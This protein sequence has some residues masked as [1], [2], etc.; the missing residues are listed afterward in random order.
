MTEPE[1]VAGAGVVE[2]DDADHRRDLGLRIRR[3]RLLRSLSL[4]AL[5]KHAG[6][7]TS[8][9]SQ[10]ERGTS[11]AS[12]SSLR[13]IASVL[14]VT[15]AE[16]FDDK[17]SLPLRPLRRRDRPT[18]ETAPGTR[19]Y[20]LTATPLRQ[21]EVYAGEFDPGCSTGPKYVHGASQELLVVV[22][23]RMRVEI[24]DTSE[25]LEAGDS[26]EYS[27]GLPHRAENCGEEVAEVLW[28]TSPPTEEPYEPAG[29]SD[30]PG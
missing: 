13:R 9:L 24:G 3:L 25:V 7:S 14:G 8:F 11:S 10:L 21:L 19:K 28:I 2:P 29:E 17:A 30:Q 6:T 18:V 15:L 20:L 1:T 16:L 5:A 22:R 4:S 12:I 26:I 27:S 23:G